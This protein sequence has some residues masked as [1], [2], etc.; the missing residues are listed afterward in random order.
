MEQAKRKKQAQR[1]RITTKLVKWKGGKYDAGKYAV[2]NGYLVDRRRLAP[3]TVASEKR[4][5]GIAVKN[6][7]CDC[8]HTLKDNQH[9][10]DQNDAHM[11]GDKLIHSGRCTY[12]K[13]CNPNL[14]EFKDSETVVLTKD[15]QVPLEQHH[16]LVEFACTN[17][18]HCVYTPTIVLGSYPTD[19]DEFEKHAKEAGAIPERHIGPVFSN[20]KTEALNLP[21]GYARCGEYKLA[22][23]W[24]LWENPNRY[25]EEGDGK[26]SR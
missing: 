4:N 14:N 16:V 9:G 8:G 17:C 5:W 11:E 20:K 13:F 12:C 1:K 15:L 10:F 21:G 24:K 19:I 18:M 3:P 6:F 26:Q 22:R 7:C 2:V 23:I 25:Q